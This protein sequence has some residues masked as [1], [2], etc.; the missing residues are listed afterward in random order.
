MAKIRGAVISEKPKSPL[1]ESV[2]TKSGTLIFRD[3]SSNSS[4]GVGLK[5]NS[6]VLDG[7]FN[8][9]SKRLDIVLEGVQGSNGTSQFSIAK[10]ILRGPFIIKTK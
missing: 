4:C 6:R 9:G 7:S 5:T 8:R 1:I 10:E 3:A 2:L